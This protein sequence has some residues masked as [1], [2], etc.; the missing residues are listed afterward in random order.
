MRTQVFYEWCYETLDDNGD[1]MDGDF[2]ERL[3]HFQDARKTNTLCL[4]RREGDNIDGESDRLYAYVKNG[5]LP[6]KFENS[7]IDVPKKFHKELKKHL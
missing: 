7:S 3:S 4:L 1:I 6:D 2:E 5:Q